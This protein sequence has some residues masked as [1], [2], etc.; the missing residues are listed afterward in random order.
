MHCLK[1]SVRKSCYNRSLSVVK[2]NVSSKRNERGKNSKLSNSLLDKLNRP[3][4]PRRK[5]LLD[6][7]RSSWQHSPRRCV[8][9]SSNKKQP[10][11]GGVNERRIA[12]AMLPMLVLL[13][14][15]RRRST[16]P[17]SSQL[18]TLL[19]VLLFSWTRMKTL[20][21]NCRLRYQR[22]PEH[23]AGIVAS[24]NSNSAISVVDVE[25]SRMI[26][27]KRRRHAHVC[28]CSTRPVLRLC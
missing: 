20:C 15:K 10:I 17:A 11:D 3:A 24:I 21:A 12:A 23:M 14:L 5:S 2:S 7:M 28:K 1:S 13:R 6:L 19:S 9:S 18:L 22:R 16:L 25:A 8:P 4:T 26:L 27:R